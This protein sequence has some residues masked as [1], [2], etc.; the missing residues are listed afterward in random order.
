M[1]GAAGVAIAA[2]VPEGVGLNVHTAVSS[3]LG[4]AAF[5]FGAVVLAGAALLLEFAPQL[6]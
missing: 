1:G 3:G 6:R 5:F 4:L 2:G